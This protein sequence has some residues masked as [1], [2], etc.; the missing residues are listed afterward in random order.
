[1]GED[2]EFEI[3]RQ[4]GVD[5][6]DAIPRRNETKFNSVR[7]KRTPKTKN[8]AKEQD[9]DTNETIS[10]M[11]ITGGATI[12]AARYTEGNSGIYHFKNVI[13]LRLDVGD[14]IVV[15]TK[16]SFS[17][18]EVQNPSVLATEIGCN[19]GRLKHV[20][21]KIDN[22]DYRRVL[23]VESEARH[24]LAMSALHERLNTMRVQLGHENF[25]QVSAMLAAPISENK[26]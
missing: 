5:I 9:M 14:L 10:L 25:G 7:E 17:I 21:A 18:V 11:Q 26:E 16:G 23:K 22:D 15:E 13:G 2:A 20:V 6:S 12:V 3:W 24:Q 8:E 4:Y 19:Y 1:M